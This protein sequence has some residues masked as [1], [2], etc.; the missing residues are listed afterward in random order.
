MERF[1][2]LSCELE[3]FGELQELD[4]VPLYAISHYLN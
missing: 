4:I 1:F 2:L 3:N